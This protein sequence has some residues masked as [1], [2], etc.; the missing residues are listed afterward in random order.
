M[1]VFFTE[2]L[3]LIKNSSAILPLVYSGIVA[4]GIAFTLQVFGQRR[5]NPALASL[6][7]GL[8]AVFAVIG[9]MVFL[10][11]RLTAREWLGCAIMLAAVL[12]VQL[13]GQQKKEQTAHEIV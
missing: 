11:E 6:I 8:E 4:V 1:A 9:G 5:V 10:G 12:L 7:M 13:K 3:P 2:S